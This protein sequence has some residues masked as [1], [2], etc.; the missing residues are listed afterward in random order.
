MLEVLHSDSTEKPQQFSENLFCITV[1]PI[2]TLLHSE[3]QKLYG[4]LAV[5]SAIEL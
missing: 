5:L 3:R 4:V 1:G 2:L